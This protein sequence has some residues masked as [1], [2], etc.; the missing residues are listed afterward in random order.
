M[1][2][3]QVFLTLS[4]NFFIGFNRDTGMARFF[5]WVRSY[6]NVLEFGWS[7]VARCPISS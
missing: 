3:R 4:N 2:T 5:T 7:K 1:R 6:W